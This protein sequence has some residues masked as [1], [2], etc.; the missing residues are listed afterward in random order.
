[1]PT[2][3]VT[4]ITGQDGAYLAQL[5]LGR[6]YKV[7]GLLRRSASADVIGT[8][9]RWLGIL[10]DIELVDANL[11][12]LSSLIRVVQQHRPDEVYNLGRTKLRRRL[13]AAAAADRRSDRHRCRQRPGGAAHRPPGNTLLPGVLVGNVW[14]Y[15]GADPERR[16]PFYPRSPYGVAKLYAHWMAVNSGKARPARLIGHSFQSRKSASRHRVRHAQDHGRRG[17]NKAWAR[18]RIP[19]GQPGCSTRLGSCTRLCAR[20]VVDA[21]TGHRRTTT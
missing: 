12:D 14:P 21:A 10:D 17:T 3:L 19:P 15:P 2:A 20:Y 1:M 5:L 8:R 9:L 16:T 18:S 4:G 7:I 6:G 11:T 13:L